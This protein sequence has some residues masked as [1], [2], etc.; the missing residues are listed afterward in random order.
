MSTA[1]ITLTIIAADGISHTLRR[2]T[3]NPHKLA[4]LTHEMRSCALTLADTDGTART[5]LLVELDGET[6]TTDVY[7]NRH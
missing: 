6:I 5:T 4:E 2:T 3:D 7:L 1:H